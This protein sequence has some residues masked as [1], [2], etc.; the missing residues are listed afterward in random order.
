MYPLDINHSDYVF[1]QN[2]IKTI[3]H[4]AAE[5]HVDNSIKDCSEFISTNINGT[6]K[7]LTLAMKYEAEKFIHISTDEVYGSTRHFVL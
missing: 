4:F 6:I 1:G 2:K 7:L 3:Y 5:S